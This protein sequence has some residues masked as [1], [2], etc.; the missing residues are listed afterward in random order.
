MIVDFKRLR[1]LIFILFFGIFGQ[2]LFSCKEVWAS[3]V[4]RIYTSHS[5]IPPEIVRKFEQETGVHVLVDVFENDDVLEAKLLSGASG[6]DLVFPTAWPYFVRQVSAELYHKIDFSKLPLAKTIDPFFRKSLEGSHRAHEFAVPFLWGIVGLAYNIDQVKKNLPKDAPVDSW[7]MLFD[8]NVAKSMAKC[9]VSLLEEATDV[10]V[11][12]KLYLHLDPASESREDLK[13]VIALLKTVRPYI[14]RFDISRSNEEIANGEMCVVQHWMG[15]V[16]SAQAQL[17]DHE[18]QSR[19]ALVVPRE[20]TL[21]WLDVMAI[22]KTSTQVDLAHQFINFVLRP[23]NI[24]LASNATFYAN[25]V[26]DSLPFIKPEIRENKAI[27]PDDE[28]LKRIV[29]HKAFSPEYQKLLTR[30]LMK[31]RSGR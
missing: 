28:T 23:D 29:L 1:A 5:Y 17:G 18:K 9:G 19:L 20:G 30:A 15:A 6:Y 10:I 27:F 7:A 2:F 22:P 16:A 26:K 3:Q 4:L 31:V 14:K 24:A 21:M 25:P 12:A 11:A 8:P 13:Q